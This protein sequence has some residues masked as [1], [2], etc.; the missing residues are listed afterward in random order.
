MRLGKL[1]K[2]GVYTVLAI[3][4]QNSI[5]VWGSEMRIGDSLGTNLT[6]GVSKVSECPPCGSKW[7]EMV[8]YSDSIPRG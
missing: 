4:N 5:Q 2:Q 1:V 7:A 8:S 6:S 3:E